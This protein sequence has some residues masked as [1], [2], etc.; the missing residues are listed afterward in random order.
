MSRILK[1]YNACCGQ[2][3]T[4]WFVAAVL[5]L[6]TA[7][8]APKSSAAVLVQDS[9]SR[10]TIVLELHPTQETLA[11]AGDLKH[12]LQAIS[13]AV[14]DIV[15]TGEPFDTPVKI[16]VGMEH[17]GLPQAFAGV[18]LAMQGY[19]ETLIAV[20]GDNV[21]LAG[22]DGKDGTTSYQRGTSQAIYTF[23]DKYLGVRWLWPGE[24]GEDVPRQVTISLD[25]IADRYTPKLQQRYLRLVS[26]GA[27]GN[28]DAD[29]NVKQIGETLDG[30]MRDWRRRHRA[31]TNWI[32]AR[33]AYT[34]WWDKY[35][36]SHPEYFALQ[37][38]GT[39]SLCT[40]PD[41]VKLCISNPEVVE[42]WLEDAV[43]QLE[44][45]PDRRMVSVA[46]NDNAYMG[47]CTC[48]DCTAW[49]TKDQSYMAQKP[50]RWAGREEEHVALT[51][52]FA[53]YW[54]AAARKLKERYPDREVL[55]GTCAYEAYRTPPMEV[56]LDENIVV[57]YVGALPASS[58]ARYEIEKRNWLGWSQQVDKLYWRPNLF[59][60]DRGMPVL[61]M[62]RAAR[63]FAWLADHGMIG[64]DVD[65][66]YGHWALQ[67]LQYYLLAKLAWDPYLDMDQAIHD[68]TTRAFGEAA[69]PSMRS[70]FQ[71]LEEVYYERIEAGEDQSKLE[72][73]TSNPAFYSQDLRDKLRAL[74]DQAMAAADTDL[75]RQR[76]QFFQA[77]L[78]FLG[79]HLNAI[80][81][82]NRLREAGDGERDA[83]Y[84]HA[85]EAAKL[86]DAFLAS[87]MDSV[88]LNTS[89]GFYNW[90]PGRSIDNCYGPPDARQRDLHR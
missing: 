63:D 14:V 65:T 27:H 67:G 44:S 73:I 72:K 4:E 79:L 33:H 13:G 81:A 53:H 8:Q 2:L 3:K 6:V 39:R 35:H 47:F 30:D 54:N 7:H 69:A 62:R 61:F 78:T 87:Q 37:P 68:Y 15:N 49:D 85:V 55:V 36:E 21:L 52:R 77:G 70:Y 64:L 23:I 28:D 66:I 82:M 57:G 5:L 38:D 41:R 58:S 46:P 32:S 89:W 75:H 31:D 29:A 25:D 45:D 86:R 11:A 56:E 26:Y 83:A 74:L 16:Y 18:D 76:V 80:D 60:A 48:A 22:R 34:Q 20:Q 59:Y 19:E 50:L 10:A 43:A 1:S 90:G 42:R 9:V 40:P 17:E 84:E 88:S 12:Y 51:D 24:L 71:L